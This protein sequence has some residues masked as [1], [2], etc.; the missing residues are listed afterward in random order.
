MT[1][2]HNEETLKSAEQYGAQFLEGNIR[3]VAARLRRMADE[4]DR[5]A[6]TVGRVGQPGAPTYGSVASDVHHTLAW[7]FANLNTDQVIRR[8]SD[9][10][11]ARTERR[12]S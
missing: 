5:C 11:I 7:G 10:D 3:A 2:P 1:T 8:A 12:A 9:A 4:V 6:D